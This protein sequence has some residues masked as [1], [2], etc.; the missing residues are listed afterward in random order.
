M[1]R[2]RKVR[3]ERPKPGRGML[4]SPIIGACLIV[5]FAY[6]A[7]LLEAAPEIVA[8]AALTFALLEG[9]VLAF[10]GAIWASRRLGMSIAVAILTALIATAGRWALGYLHAG[11]RAPAFTDLLED[12]AVTIAWAAFCG[13]AG[14]TVLRQ[15]V[16]ALMPGR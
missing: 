13:F 1:A 4:L 7:S 5:T 3:V 14:G 12:L 10:I 2:R 11:G 16:S 8:A 6:A 9:V 15:R